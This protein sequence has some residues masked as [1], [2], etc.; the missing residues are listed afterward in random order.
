MKTVEVWNIVPGTN[1]IEK[2][3]MEVKEEGPN[4]IYT[5]SGE[6]ISYDPLTNKITL[7]DTITISKTKTAITMD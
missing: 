4:K 5:L 1:T 2:A 6:E 3:T 7:P